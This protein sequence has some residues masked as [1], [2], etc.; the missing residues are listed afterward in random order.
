[1]SSKVIQSG[2]LD[3]FFVKQTSESGITLLME[4]LGQSIGNSDIQAMLGGG[5]PAIIPGVIKSFE[6]ELT[7]LMKDREKL[8]ASLGNYDGPQGNTRFIKNLVRYFNQKY[9]WQL[10][11]KNF[12]ITAGSQSGF[13]ILF[14]LFSGT[15]SLGQKKRILFPYSPEYIGYFNLN[16][17]PETLVG[18]K[19]KINI[20]NQEFK[21]NLDFEAIEKSQD[22]GAICISRPC[23]PSGN[24]CTDEEVQK[25]QSIAD[26]RNIPLI[27]DNAYG[28]PFPDIQFTT[29]NLYF[30]NNTILGFSLS[31]LGFPTARVGI[32]IAKEEYIR[33]ITHAN[34]VLALSGNRLAQEMVAGLFKNDLIDDLVINQIKPFYKQKKDLF[35]EVFSEVFSDMPNC[36]IHKPEGSL[37]FWLWVKD[38]QQ[39]FLDL[40]YAG[41]FSEFLYQELKKSGIIIV[42]GHYFFGALKEDWNHKFECLRLNYAREEKEIR[43]GLKKIK[44]AIQKILQ[45]PKNF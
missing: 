32:I 40:G 19:P 10:T 21:Y 1:M 22:I 31:K 41:I 44:L 4:D 2:L 29:N 18:L 23:N 6:K 24:I 33:A 28:E 43:L 7:G 9:N 20:Q 17:E 11:E 42:S 16:I 3:N 38:S 26:Q 27:I 25:L 13:F 39:M 30:T 34:G 14:N 12:A 35:L 45:T 8:I 37:F 36:L 15:N 5:N